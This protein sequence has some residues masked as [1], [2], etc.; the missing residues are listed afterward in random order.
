MITTDI[1]F[2][3]SHNF[4]FVALKYFKFR[5]T[6]FNKLSYTSH[7]HSV[8]GYVP[9]KDLDPKQHIILF[10][11]EVIKSQLFKQKYKI[12]SLSDNLRSTSEIS[13]FAEKFRKNNSIITR[14]IQCQ[15]SHNFHGES[16]DIRTCVEFSN[17]INECASTIQEYQ[18]KSRGLDFLPVIAQ[19]P[20]ELLRIVLSCLVRKNIQ[21]E[22]S[23]KLFTNYVSENSGGLPIVRIFRAEEV[24]GLEFTVV[25][26]LLCEN[27][28]FS[29]GFLSSFHN[30]ITGACVKLVI[31]YIQNKKK[32]IT[33]QTMRSEFIERL[34]LEIED[35]KTDRAV[36]LIG[37]IIDV[38]ILAEV[39]DLELHHRNICKPSIESMRCFMGPNNVI[40]F[41]LE[42][43]YKKRDLE[44]L[45]RVQL[46][47]IFIVGCTFFCESHQLLLNVLTNRIFNSEPFSGYFEVRNLASWY[48]VGKLS[49]FPLEYYLELTDTSD[50]NMM[51]RLKNFVYHWE[52]SED[53]E[54]L[55]SIPPYYRWYNWKDRVKELR[56]LKHTTSEVTMIWYSSLFSTG[57]IQENFEFQK[58]SI[59]YSRELKNLYL[60]FGKL[61][62]KEISKPTYI[63]NDFALDSGEFFSF[64]WFALQALCLASDVLEREPCCPRA[65]HLIFQVLKIIRAK[66]VGNWAEDNG[67][68]KLMQQKTS[69]ENAVLVIGLKN[70]AVLKCEVEFSM[71]FFMD[72][73]FLSQV[74]PEHSVTAIKQKASVISDAA[75]KMLN[76]LLKNEIGRKGISERLNFY[77]TML[78]ALLLGPIRIS[79]E[80]LEWNPNQNEVTESLN[81]S[82]S[83]F[84]ELVN[85][86]HNL[87][88]KQEKTNLT[89]NHR[90]TIR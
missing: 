67:D 70:F 84:A 74:S 90:I 52:T 16:P 76:K 17:F 22:M 61:Q 89:R 33:E 27:D 7:S 41:Q 80:S 72:E 5:K 57:I 18:E 42:D 47:K 43:I 29:C 51:S 46:R 2:C 24:T 48:N 49:F 9:L 55:K 50:R 66:I 53:A 21:F 63:S 88:R 31:V 69:L 23:Q 28:D 11:S 6:L 44:E 68:E 54:V 14:E 37:T 32:Q 15:P 58:V 81:K 19:M 34:K 62:L 56:R 1:L 12:L 83:F 71:N 64:Q 35:S 85:E 36:V 87:A 20:R 75:G 39:S 82:I 38:N 77:N 73:C 10:T 86:V 3:K 25:I 60:K 79:L 4:C 13:N 8:K 30:I 40:F 59:R 78:C 45:V 26:S 65:Y